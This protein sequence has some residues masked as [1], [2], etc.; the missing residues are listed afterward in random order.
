MSFSILVEKVSSENFNIICTYETGK[1][2]YLRFKKISSILKE[3]IKVGNICLERSDVENT[4]NRS[5]EVIKSATI[6]TIGA[7][8]KDGFRFYHKNN[9]NPVLS[10][11][12]LLKNRI[13]YTKNSPIE[14]HI[15]EFTTNSYPWI[16]DL[17]EDNIINN[18]ILKPK[19]R[20]KFNI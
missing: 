7:I 6:W 19:T 1:V 11:E 17:E 12:N 2:R 14:D 18:K 16:C 8:E 4:S 10:L 15:W 13:E 9:N 20:L 5:M 3:N